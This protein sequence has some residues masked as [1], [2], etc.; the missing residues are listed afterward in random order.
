M[1]V[2]LLSYNILNGFCGD[3]PLFVVDKRRLR[4]GIKILHQAKADVVGL[5]EAFIYP[6][7]EQTTSYASFFKS[8]YIDRYIPQTYF[9]FAPLTLSHFKQTFRDLSTDK[10]KCLET[11]LLI[12][13]KKLIIWN[14]HTGH[15]I[16]DE[17][18]VQLIEALFKKSKP[19]IIMGD[20]NGTSQVDPYDREKL[21]TAF[22]RFMKEG[23]SDKVRDLLKGALATKLLDAGYQDSFLV[24][25]KPWHYTIP[26]NMRS[27]NKDSGVRIDFIF[28]RK[29]LKVV[30]A[31][32]IMS[33]ETEVASDHY[34]V[35]AIIEI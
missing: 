12:R 3:T 9:R 5:Q 29:R 2:K 35:Y 24:S 18:R 15:D 16:S 28:L 20:F 13:K 31:G 7:A 8:L 14:I 26:T 17:S 19:D 22:S 33:K 30:D 10:C 6:L 11:T 25:K 27:K 23:A 34:P 1:K 4:A 21:C 32:I